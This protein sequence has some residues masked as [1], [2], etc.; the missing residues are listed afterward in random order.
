MYVYI[1]NTQY[2]LAAPTN[3]A[4][5]TPI[6]IGNIIGYGDDFFFMNRLLSSTEVSNHWNGL[7]STI[8]SGG[9]FL[10]NFC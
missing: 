9:S 7:D 8:K 4:S 5:L 10:M 2:S 3:Y 6:Y 1:D